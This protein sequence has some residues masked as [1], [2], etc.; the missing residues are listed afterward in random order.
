MTEEAKPKSN[1]LRNI[2]LGVGGIFVV[3][4]VIGALAGEDKPQSAGAATATIPAP[5]QA[6]VPDLPDLA[7]VDRPGLSGPA[8]NA[9]R[10]AESYLSM[11]GFSK[12]GLIN[13]LSS[14]AGE[15]YELADATAAVESL[16]VD[17]NEQAVRS[18]KTYLSMMG[19]SCS[20]LVEQ[21]SADAG[22]KFTAS[23][24][25]YGAQQ[26]GAC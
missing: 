18:A 6:Q 26:A 5:S 20:G 17:W 12:A 13:Q 9:R 21:L 7:D 11:Q 16:D 10:S 4:I 1:L 3:L 8:N 22:E 23:Q 25:R 14:S 15:G 24:A 19:F 2:C